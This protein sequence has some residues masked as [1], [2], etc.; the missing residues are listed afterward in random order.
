MIHNH[1]QRNQF[2]QRLM[3]ILTYCA[4]HISIAKSKPSKFFEQL[5][6]AKHSRWWWSPTK[7]PFMLLFW[8]TGC[9][10]SFFFF[11]LRIQRQ[12]SNVVCTN[13]PSW[14]ILLIFVR[15][16]YLYLNPIKKKK[17]TRSVVYFWSLICDR[18]SN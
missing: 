15:Y 16:F 11:G 4:K 8:F 7:W 13:F 5:F 6:S 9:L 3:C 2:C 12:L 1:Y 10:L 18:L 17:Q 14:L